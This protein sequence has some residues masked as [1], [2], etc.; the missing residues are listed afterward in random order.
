M[1]DGDQVIDLSLTALYEEVGRLRRGHVE[2]LTA[3]RRREGEVRAD[4]EAVRRSIDDMTL[5]RADLVRDREA[6]RDELD[7]LRGHAG[8]LEGE[9]A[10]MKA[11]TSW[12]LTA[13]VRWAADRVR[14]RR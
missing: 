8:R 1:S 11:S 13:P 10:A 14:R 12:R 7:A 4:L 6:L 5:E 2:A 3:G 9:I